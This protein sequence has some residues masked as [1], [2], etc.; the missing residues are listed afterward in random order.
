M[1]RTRAVCPLRF[2][3]RPVLPARRFGIVALVSKDPAGADMSATF[4]DPSG[5]ARCGLPYLCAIEVRELPNHHFSHQVSRNLVARV[6]V[7]V[8]RLQIR[9]FKSRSITPPSSFAMPVA[10]SLPDLSL[11]AALTPDIEIAMA[12]TVR[13]LLSTPS[14]IAE[15]TL[16]VMDAAHYGSHQ[17][18]VSKMLQLRIVS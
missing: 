1:Q 5:F 15:Q 17:S 4:S 7:E 9:V 3:R 13:L 11:E 6:L 16:S 14:C 10:P 8:L 2:R 12:I 18:S